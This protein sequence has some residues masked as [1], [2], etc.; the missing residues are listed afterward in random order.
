MWRPF[1]M[2]SVT[3]YEERVV[4]R[5]AI[6]NH[7]KILCG[8]DDEV[9]SYLIKWIAQMIQFPAI[10][11]ICPVLISNEGAG[12]G[13]LL[14]LFAKMLGSSKVFETTTPSRD[15]WGDFN[16]R[17]ANTFL[18]NLNELSKKETIESEGRIKGLITDATLTINNK[19]ANQYDIQSFHRFII[20]TNKEE[21]INTSKTDR[22][23]LIIR[24]SDEKCGDKE[25]FKILHNYIEDMN[26]IKTMYEFFKNMNEV[27]HFMSIPIPETEYHEQL[28][29]LSANPIESW[30]LHFVTENQ[31]LETVELTTSRAFEL[32]N[33][34]CL[35]TGIK[36]DCSSLQ[37]GVRLTR[38][39][40]KGISKK[41]TNSCNKTIFDITILKKHFEM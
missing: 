26:V 22:R 39:N 25:Y 19:N 13:T 2:E 8:N 27:E 3:K 14:K 11:T 6:L 40:L 33:D 7:I 32:F 16:G 31:N 38:L 18:I 17:M 41:K 9:Y 28:K 20:T 23:K 4:E 35:E 29:E 37:F 10:K 21:P 34:W 30:L 5:D 15:I 12:K 36:Y 24:S 1:A